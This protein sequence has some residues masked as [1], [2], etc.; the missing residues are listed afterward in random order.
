MYN[1]VKYTIIAVS[2]A[3]AFLMA[4]ALSSRV[5]EKIELIQ[6]PEYA[7]PIIMDGRT[8]CEKKSELNLIE[9]WEMKCEENGA[10]KNC[11]LPKKDVTPLFEYKALYMKSCR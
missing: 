3:F 2:M 1:F 8:V 4:L 6:K 9:S 11:S 5:Q 7:S 10:E